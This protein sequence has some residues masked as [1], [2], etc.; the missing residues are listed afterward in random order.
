[1]ILRVK[2]SIFSHNKNSNRYL[3]LAVAKSVLKPDAWAYYSSGA[4]DEISM[5]ENH[6]A[7]H[8]IWLRPRV[9]V[10]V[11]DVD[12]STTM[13][14]S[15]TAL[16][17]YITATAL[18]KLGHPEGEVVLTKAAKARNIIQM[19]PTLASCSFDEI[20]DA[21]A[22][23][24]TQWLQLY[25]NGNRQVS[26]EFVRHAEKRGMKG[27]FITADAPQLGILVLHNILRVYLVFPR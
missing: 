26:E 8:R 9:M 15:R 21:A 13:L 6:N 23:G 19:I 10:N 11:K 25:V 27:L 4:D 5:R 20:V 17:L 22:P 18:G 12:A 1:L 24:Q 16:P 7:F 14:G 2:S 3:T